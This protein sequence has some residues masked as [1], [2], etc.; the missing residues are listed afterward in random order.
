M[1][2]AVR[3]KQGATTAAA[4]AAGCVRSVLYGS[5]AKGVN[6]RHRDT[7][8]SACVGRA[9]RCACGAITRPGAQSTT[10]SLTH[11]RLQQKIIIAQSSKVSS[12]RQSTPHYRRRCWCTLP[13]LRRRWPRNGG[14]ALTWPHHM[15]CLG[16]ID[17]CCGAAIL[18]LPS[19]ALVTC[20]TV[21]LP[22]ARQACPACFSRSTGSYRRHLDQPNQVWSLRYATSAAPT[23]STKLAQQVYTRT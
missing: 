19:L 22:S 10:T 3:E 5:H 11:S 2:E 20:H 16:E 6:R 13:A 1:R 17:R 9:V 12:S 18:L 23:V 14:L 4:A 15:G 8:C 21:G 7:L